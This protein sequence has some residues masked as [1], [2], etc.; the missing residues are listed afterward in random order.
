M[1]LY[2]SCYSDS[3]LS[4]FSMS[5]MH[6]TLSCSEF[7]VMCFVW[8][9]LPF[10]DRLMSHAIDFSLFHNFFQIVILSLAHISEN[11][12]I[13]GPA[14][15]VCLSSIWRFQPHIMLLGGHEFL[16]DCFLSSLLFVCRS[17]FYAAL[18]WKSYYFKSMFLME[19]DWKG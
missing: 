14:M 8:S 17:R 9:I 3:D 12:R 16:K 7:P 11:L 2:H 18:F 19:H 6:V 10:G 4:P 1:I 15:V 5:V 13:Y